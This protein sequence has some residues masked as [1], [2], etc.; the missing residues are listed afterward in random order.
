MFERSCTS[1]NDCTRRRFLK[2]IGGFAAIAAS[3]GSTRTFATQ[4]DRV[5][6]QEVNAYPIYINQRSEGLLDPPTFNGDDD[7]RRWS[8]GGPFE[9]LPSAIIAIIKTD[10]GITGFGMGAGGTAAR[11]IIDGHLKHLLIGTNALNPEQLWDQMYTSGV[12]YGR[13]GLFT[14]ALSCLLYTSPS[15]RD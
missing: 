9:Q 2:G 12:L 3:V 5:E 7:P 13:R 11:E 6:I 10:Q 4:I 8:Y 1:L 14:M 15:P